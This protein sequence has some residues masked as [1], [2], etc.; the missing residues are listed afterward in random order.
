MLETLV[1]GCYIFAFVMKK[2]IL[3]I[4]S[5]S[6]NITELLKKKIK[7]IRIKTLTILIVILPIGLWSAQPRAL[8]RVF[9]VNYGRVP[10]LQVLSDAGWTSLVVL[11]LPLGQ[12]A[13][14]LC[15]G[16]NTLN[17]TQEACVGGKK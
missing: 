7:L 3:K 8:L 17:C 16:I 6:D 4:T 13:L 10:S 12:E 2:K 1:R 11:Q 5:A 9:W 15:S 14:Q